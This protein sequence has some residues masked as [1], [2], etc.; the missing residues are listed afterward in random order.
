MPRSQPSAWAIEAGGPMLVPLRYALAPAGA[1][2]FR[3]RRRPTDS[4]MKT[5]TLILCLTLLAGCSSGPSVDTRYS[6]ASQS[7]RVQYVILHYTSADFA[8]SL[9]LLTQD[10]VSSHY[11]ISDES[12]PRIYRLVDENRRAWHSG[13]STWQ[14]RTWL[15]ASSIGIESVHP[16]YTVDASGQRIWHPYPEAQIELLIEL[17]KDIQTRH[18]LPPDSIIGHSDVAPQ[19]KVDP[20]PQFPWQRLAEAGLLR[21]P[22][23][24]AVQREQA[25][26][27]QL[28]DADWFQQALARVGYTVPRTG[29][30]DEATRRVLA[31]FQMKYRPQRHDGVADL[32]SAALLQVLGRSD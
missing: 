31:A 22:D 2:S 12:K 9:E 25:A 5:C 24:A 10:E 20:G 32:Q 15:N 28:P 3:P 8:R 7:S 4:P 27:A 21:W 18:G 26:L 11:L 1:V 14:G 30:W 17:L 29:E 13:D 19:R 6:A 16:G 23:A